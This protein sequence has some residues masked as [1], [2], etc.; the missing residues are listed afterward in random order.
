MPKLAFKPIILEGELENLTLQEC[1]ARWPAPPEDPMMV[2]ANPLQPIQP[3]PADQTIQPEPESKTDEP[4]QQSD[5][6]ALF[7]Y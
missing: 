7:R 2:P 1:M 5:E 3:S 6:F 4:E